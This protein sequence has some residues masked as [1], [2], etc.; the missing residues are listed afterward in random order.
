MTISLLLSQSV[1]PYWPKFRILPE[2]SLRNPTVNLEVSGTKF[3]PKVPEILTFTKICPKLPEFCSKM[4]ENGRKL[5]PFY[6]KFFFQKILVKNFKIIFQ[7]PAKLSHKNAIK[8]GARNFRQFLAK[9]PIFFK[10]FLATL[11]SQ[12][13]PFEIK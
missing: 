13:S 10:K 11:I 5:T 12:F 9:C 2:I 4:D 6:E 8:R 3:C 1:L 7:N